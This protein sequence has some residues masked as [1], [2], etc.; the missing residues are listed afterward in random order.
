MTEQMRIERTRNEA[1]AVKPNS[2]NVL[3]VQL[4]VDEHLSETQ[5]RRSDGCVHVRSKE[6]AGDHAE[7]VRIE[8][9]TDYR[10]ALL[11][12]LR[13]QCQSPGFR[14]RVAID[15]KHFGESIPL[16]QTDDGLDGQPPS[17]ISVEIRV[18]TYSNQ[19]LPNI[20]RD[21]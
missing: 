16:S 14:K 19:M 12:K 3:P 7:R 11:V 13:A 10:P 17:L 8:L 1:N 20:I 18:S 4:D 15:R 6:P 2:D 9:R 5:G 21:R